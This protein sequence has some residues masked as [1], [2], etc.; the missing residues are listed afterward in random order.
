VLIASQEAAAAP[1]ERIE[2]EVAKLFRKAVE[3][4]VDEL[5]CS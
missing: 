5:E 1:Y 2:E 3:K 4:W